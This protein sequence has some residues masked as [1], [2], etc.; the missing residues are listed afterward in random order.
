MYFTFHLNSNSRNNEIHIYE[1]DNRRPLCNDNVI[2][3]KTAGIFVNKQIANDKF[4]ENDAR[5]F[6]AL[7]QNLGHNVCGVCMSAMYLTR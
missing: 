7:L 3:G 5:I 1:D 2:K 6:A 4:C